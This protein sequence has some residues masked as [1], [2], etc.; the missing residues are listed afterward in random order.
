[1]NAAQSAGALIDPGQYEALF[2]EYEIDK[3]VLPDLVEAD[4]EKIGVPLGHR[5]QPARGASLFSP[6]AERHRQL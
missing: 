3:D 4:L 2:R 1:M 5:K 6:R